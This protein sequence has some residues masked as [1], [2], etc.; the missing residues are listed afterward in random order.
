MPIVAANGAM[1][2]RHLPDGGIQWLLVK[3]GV[4]T[5]GQCA[6]HCTAASTWSSKWPAI[7]LHFLLLLISLLA[8]T[9]DKNI[10]ITIYN[11]NWDTVLFISMF[12]FYL[13]VWGVRRP[14][15]MPFRSPLLAA[16][17]QYWLNMGSSRNKLISSLFYCFI[18][19]QAQALLPNSFGRGSLRWI[20]QINISHSVGA[21][22]GS[23]MVVMFVG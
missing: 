3:L 18:Q 20:R 8:T 4:C 7:C 22:N 12:S 23:I 10:V 13:F 14:Q 5:I 2:R 16:D 11:K 15:W 6:L 19:N 17:E 21:A 1:R 9:I